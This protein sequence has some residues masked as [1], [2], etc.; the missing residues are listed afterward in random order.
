MPTAPCPLAGR[1]SSGGNN[2]RIRSAFL[3]DVNR[4]RQNDGIVVTSIEFCQTN[5]HCHADREF[6]G[7][8]AG[9]VTGTAGAGW[10]CRRWRLGNS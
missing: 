4:R 10:R 1:L 8:G 3:T 9:R 6:A 5:L 2:E 7:R